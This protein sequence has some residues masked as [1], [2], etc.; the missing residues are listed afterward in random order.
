METVREKMK[1]A[2]QSG[3][4]NKLNQAI[5]AWLHGTLTDEELEQR[6]EIERENANAKNSG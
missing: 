4:G 3:D 6:R 5:E 2:I 1:D